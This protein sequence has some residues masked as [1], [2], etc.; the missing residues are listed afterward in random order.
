ME[1]HLMEL[2]S[3]NCC[4]STRININ[5]TSITLFQVPIKTNKCTTSDNDH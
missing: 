5:N 1:L 4:F 2:R 3:I